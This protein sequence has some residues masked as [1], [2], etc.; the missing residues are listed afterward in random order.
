MAV[1]AI[2]VSSGIKSKRVIDIITKL[3]ERKKRL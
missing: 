3:L 2:L 1:V